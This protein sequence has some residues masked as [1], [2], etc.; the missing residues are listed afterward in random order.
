MDA[1]SEMEKNVNNK[2][3][4]A[5]QSVKVYLANLTNFEEA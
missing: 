5:V 2:I 4:T 1:L 3:K